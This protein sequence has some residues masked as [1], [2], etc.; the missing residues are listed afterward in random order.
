MIHRCSL[1]ALV[2]P[3]EVCHC[4]FLEPNSHVMLGRLGEITQRKLCN[5]AGEV[6][7]GNTDI[8]KALEPTMRAEAST[9]RALENCML[10][11]V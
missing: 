4:Q 7:E 3:H 10:K 6:S 9:R 2:Q 8:F 11:G 1:Q 5:H